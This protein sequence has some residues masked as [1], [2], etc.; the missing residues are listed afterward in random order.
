MKNL[1]LFLKFELI[2]FFFLIC[3]NAYSA[4]IPYLNQIS[5]LDETDQ[6][7]EILVINNKIK[8]VLKDSDKFHDVN[9]VFGSKILKVDYNFINSRIINHINR[10]ISFLNKYFLKINNKLK[11]QTSYQ[12]RAFSYDFEENINTLTRIVNNVNVLM[13]NWMNYSIILYSIIPKCFEEL[14]F[15]EDIMLQSLNIDH[16]FFYTLKKNR[17]V[18]FEPIMYSL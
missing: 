17:C 14:Y 15:Q 6:V 16:A 10:A 11:G 3:T 18:F 1:N 5:L 2:I 7:Y 4:P 8:K 9:E 12:F 13:S